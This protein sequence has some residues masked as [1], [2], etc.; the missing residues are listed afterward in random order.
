VDPEQVREY[1]ALSDAVTQKL[2]HHAYVDD[3]HLRHVLQYLILPSFTPP[4]AWDVFR[5][6][7]QELPGKH[8]LIRSCWQSDLDHEKLRTPPE[9]A[10][11]PYPLAP[12]MEVH[13]LTA[14]SAELE[15]L[16]HDL[17]ALE[18]RIGATSRVFGCDG[19]TFEVAIDQ[20]PETIAESARCRLSWWSEPPEAWRGLREWV[21][22]AE[23]VFERAWLARTNASERQRQVV[24]VNDG[25]AREEARRLFREGHYGR[26]TELLVE[27]A[28]RATLSPAQTKMLEMSLQRNRTQR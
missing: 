16:A 25:A 18:L 1:G 12:T 9:R 7:S 11:H 13:E 22:R 17:E 6:G 15:Q 20:P 24:T 8:V 4:I 14:S 26:V 2:R 23:D 21:G 27:I 19:V 3:Q 5:Q 10:R 28:S